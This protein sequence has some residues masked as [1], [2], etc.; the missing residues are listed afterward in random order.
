MLF[1]LSHDEHVS[2]IARAPLSLDAVGKNAGL[3]L[4]T[5]DM[6]MLYFSEK[7]N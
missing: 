1:V 3:I 6:A 5:R 7:R 2:W 4:Q